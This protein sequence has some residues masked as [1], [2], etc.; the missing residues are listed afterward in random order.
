MKFATLPNPAFH[1]KAKNI[2]EKKHGDTDGN[3]QVSSVLLKVNMIGCMRA[4]RFVVIS[5][6][7]VSHSDL[8]YV[9]TLIHFS[10]LV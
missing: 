1:L 8:V 7:N 2:Y 3:S 5:K 4:I 6:W 10:D 9:R